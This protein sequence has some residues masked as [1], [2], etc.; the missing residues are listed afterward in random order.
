MFH[1]EA[2]RELGRGW[3]LVERRA[4]HF[5]QRYPH[6]TLY[7]EHAHLSIPKTGHIYKVAKYNADLPALS[8]NDLSK[9][10]GTA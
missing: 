1:D 7:C 3:P 10:L 8:P 5:K 4:V 6:A 2:L 9:I